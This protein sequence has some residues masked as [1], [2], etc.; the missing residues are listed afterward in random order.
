V[1]VCIAPAPVLPP[2]FAP[3]GGGG[4]CG[5]ASTVLQLASSTIYYIFFYYFFLASTKAF[6]A[7]TILPCVVFLVFKSS[8]VQTLERCGAAVEINLLLHT[9]VVA[10]LGRRVIFIN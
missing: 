2:P 8:N 3:L 9:T 4:G 6:F 10:T 5:D 7:S 1:S